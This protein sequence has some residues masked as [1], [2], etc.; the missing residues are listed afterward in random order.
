[1]ATSLLFNLR[2]LLDHVMEQRFK[3]PKMLAGRRVDD[4]R[5]LLP[6]GLD[7]SD[8]KAMSLQASA[9]LRGTESNVKS[10]GSDGH[11]L[12]R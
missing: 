10:V 1:M 3:L 5:S 6:S 9:D 12:N 4:D 2:F 7:P 8:A 11:R